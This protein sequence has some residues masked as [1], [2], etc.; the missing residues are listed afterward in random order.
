VYGRE[1]EASLKPI[2][3]MSGCATASQHMA[4][5]LSSGRRIGPSECFTL[6]N[7]KLEENMQKN[8][9]LKS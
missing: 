6:E 9:F 7:L 1:R 5:L 2:E 3:I 8:I 4:R